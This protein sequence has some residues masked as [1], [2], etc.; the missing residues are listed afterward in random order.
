MKF[1]VAIEPGIDTTAFG[2][3]VPDLPGCYSAGATLDEAV[4]NARE[5]I[6]LWCET[7][8]EDGGD[9]PVA[10]NWLHIRPMRISRAGFGWWLKCRL[11]VSTALPKKRHSPCRV[12][13]SQRLTNTP[14][15]TAKHALVFWPRRRGMRCGRGTAGCNLS[16][17]P[18]SYFFGYYPDEA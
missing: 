13:Y 6:D 4:D 5:A 16:L 9:V 15:P 14:A 11:S 1:I 8:I 17:E 7:V 3:V 2:V 18:L 10:R 12:Y